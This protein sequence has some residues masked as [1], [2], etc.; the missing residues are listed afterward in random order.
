MT[1][2]TMDEEIKRIREYVFTKYVEGTHAGPEQDEPAALQK[3]RDHHKAVP[4]AA[5]GDTYYL[6]ILFFELAYSD[7]QHEK[8][9]L[10]RAKWILDA[11]RTRTGEAW[12][13]VDDRIDDASGPFDDLPAPEREKLLAAAKAEMAIP[14]E[15]AKEEKRGPVIENGMVLVPGGAFLSGPAK[16]QRETK[17][18]WIDQRP[19][20][21]ADYRRYC[22]ITGYRPPKY[23][24]EGK[25]RDDGSPVVGVSWYDA[26]KYA[27][28]AGKSLPSKD[29]WEKA[30]RGRSGRLYP[31]GDEYDAA[32]A[33]FHGA[34]DASDDA[35]EAVGKM[36]R[37]MEDL[38]EQ[39]EA[40][41]S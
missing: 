15:P 32:K 41:S 24:P 22:E 17:A 31:W 14:A 13:P 38:R 21:N 40:K 12:A 27:A 6:G 8:D 18:F 26:F 7:P 39:A 28:W 37:L 33:S 9:Y 30:A 3:L 10:A 11:W 4:V 5:D 25:F 20:T 36:D 34:D 23:W 19:V 1:T 29:Q 16:Q 35:W 2:M